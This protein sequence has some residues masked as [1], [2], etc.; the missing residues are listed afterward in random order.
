MEEERALIPAPVRHG[1][2]GR[3]LPRTAATTAPT[4]RMSVPKEPAT[5]LTEPRSHRAQGP[6]RG[7]QDMESDS[8]AQASA[9]RW[10]IGWSPR[11]QR[12]PMT[13]CA[14]LAQRRAKVCMTAVEGDQRWSRRFRR[15][16][17]R[18]LRTMVRQLREASPLP[19]GHG[20]E[21]TRRRRAG[22]GSPRAKGRSQ[23]QTVEARQ[24]LA[25]VLNVSRRVGIRASRGDAVGY[26]G[27]AVTPGGG[28]RGFADPWC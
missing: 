23:S 1:R 7:P 11:R 5:L 16:G 10:P 17:R 13:R 12:D 24:G 26:A 8:E 3:T 22:R 25:V 15:H 27:P 2:R 28:G 18:G 14:P 21:G 20:A 19:R 6:V 9:N 4:G